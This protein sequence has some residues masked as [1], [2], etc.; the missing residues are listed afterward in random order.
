MQD[1]LKMILILA[2]LQSL[3][4]FL[5]SIENLRTSFFS[6]FLSLGLMILIVYYLLKNRRRGYY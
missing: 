6:V 1:S 2:F 3:L 4:V 5:S